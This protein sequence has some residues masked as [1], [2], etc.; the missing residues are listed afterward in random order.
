MSQQSRIGRTATSIYTENGFTSVRYHSTEV[1]KFNHEKI[2]L[3]TGGWHTFT[4]K[5]R[6]NQA[7]R[8]FDLGYSVSQ[9]NYEWFVSF[10]GK[11]LP[12][13]D[14]IELVR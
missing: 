12:F 5:T 4:T 9:K 6:M 11:S 3:N 8:Q 1:V 14:E 13:V 7:S 2:I 10:K